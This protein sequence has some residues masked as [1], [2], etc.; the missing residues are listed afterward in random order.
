M[1][2]HLK[3]D[4]LHEILDHSE[5]RSALVFTR[6]KHGADRLYR[7][8]KARG[9]R[10]GVIHGDRSQGQRER[11]LEE[12]K[13]GRVE[14]LVAT[15]IASR[16]IDVDDITHVINYDVP[17]APEDYVHRIGRTGRM[18]ASGD[19]ITL[20]SPEEDKDAR[21]IEKFLGR[22]I[23]QETV[24]GF[25]YKGHATKVGHAESSEPARS[26]GGRGSHGAVHRSGGHASA[27][28]QATARATPSGPSHGRRRKV[29]VADRRSRRKM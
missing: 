20:V 15:D 17:R 12:F 13:R 3:V 8:L 11:A 22:R 26:R 18:N 5:D 9:H 19:A 29:N 23:P 4:L 7:Q 6:T 10:V 28:T 27:G 16:G 14:V 1:P 2:R 24:K 25:D 21:A